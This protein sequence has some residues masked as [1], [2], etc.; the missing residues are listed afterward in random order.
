VA[1]ILNERQRQ[2]LEQRYLILKNQLSLFGQN[3]PLKINF[4]E[5]SFE[6]QIAFVK[7]HSDG[8]L[9]AAQ[10]TRRAAKSYSCGIHFFE[11]SKK[12]PNSNYIYFTLTRETAR[13]IFWKD[14]LK[15][16]DRR[17]KVGCTFNESRLQCTT[18]WGAQITLIGVDADE[19]DKE[20]VLGQKIRWAYGDES[21]F[22]NINLEEL[23]YDM[24]LPA[25]ADLNGGVTLISTTSNRTK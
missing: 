15:D 1:K 3:D 17:F 24:L 8:K 19:K 21:A 22:F 9:M 5:G 4:F 12:F 25:T 14:V 16:I 6:S 23:V 13:K 20:K 7:A 11:D 10:C 18:P 2:A